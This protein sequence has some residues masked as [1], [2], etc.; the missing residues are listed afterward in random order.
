MGK[1]LS[2]VPVQRDASLRPT[3]LPVSAAAT[4]FARPDRKDE[5]HA[6]LLPDV[7]P[8]FQSFLILRRLRRVSKTRQPLLSLKFSL[9]KQPLAFLQLFVRLLVV[10]GKSLR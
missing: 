8:L 3:V 10:Q 6:I 9:C 5:A 4:G 1:P 2:P 7:R